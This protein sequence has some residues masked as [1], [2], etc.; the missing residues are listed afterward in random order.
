MARS[1]NG[2]I[3]SAWRGSLP[4]FANGYGARYLRTRTLAPDLATMLDAPA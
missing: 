1:R 4:I 2:S 3:D